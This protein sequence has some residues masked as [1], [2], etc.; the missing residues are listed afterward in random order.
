MLLGHCYMV[1]LDMYQCID[2]EGVVVAYGAGYELY[3]PRPLCSQWS[4]A[5]LSRDE[6]QDQRRPPSP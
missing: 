1:D 3:G 4:F 6:G 2:L 5:E